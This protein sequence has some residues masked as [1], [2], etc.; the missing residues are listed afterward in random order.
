MAKINTKIIYED[1]EDIL[2]LS[3]GKLARAS[4]EIGD[5]VID[6]DSKGYIIAIEI[7]NA[8]QNLKVSPKVFSEI[9]KAS[10]SVV[11]KPNY[12]YIM[13][14]FNFKEKEKDVAIPLTIDLGH[15]KVQKQEVIFAK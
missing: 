4:I 5:F 3:E 1:N 7:L 10:M 14:I 6:V 15:K 13:L 9:N 2:Y 12:L 11:Y 8:S